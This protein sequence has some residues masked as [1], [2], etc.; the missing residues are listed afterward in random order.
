V[1]ETTLMAPNV[2]A[3]WTNSRTCTPN[4]AVAP[5]FQADRHDG[6]VLAVG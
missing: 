2:T 1:R 3:G 4:I 5:R 6:V